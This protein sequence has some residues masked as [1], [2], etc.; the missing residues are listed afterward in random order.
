MLVAVGG[1]AVGVL[2][3]VGGLEAVGASVAGIPAV[4][5]TGVLVSAGTAATATSR[6][7]GGDGS[8]RSPFQAM[9]PMTASSASP[10]TAA[11]QSGR[12]RDG[13]VTGMAV[14]TRAAAGTA[15]AAWA[16]TASSAPR[17]AAA[18][19]KRVSFDR[20]NAWL[21]MATMAGDSP[22]AVCSS[23]VISSGRISRSVA[24]AGARPVRMK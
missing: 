12:A 18:E 11:S 2:V 1:A 17:M 19:A 23:G 15:P 3:M 5:S 10:A 13:A 21:M 22:G 24:A 4:A 16:G 20:A 14:V 8:P 6:D 9:K 7:G